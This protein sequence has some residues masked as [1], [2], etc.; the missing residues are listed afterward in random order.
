MA[1]IPYMKFYIGD[2]EQ[3]LNACSLQ[4]EAAWLKVVV[5]MFKDQESG[6]YKTTTK[7]LQRIWKCSTNDVQEII[8]ELKDEMV[9]GIEI[10]GDDVVFKNRRMLKAKGISKIRSDAVQNRYKTS[11]KGITKEVQNP[12]YEYEHDNEYENNNVGVPNLKEQ[13]N[14]CEFIFEKFLKKKYDP[15]N[16]TPREYPFYQD[17]DTEINSLAKEGADFKHLLQRIKSY[18]EYTQNTGQRAAVKFDS[19]IRKA[20]EANWNELLKNESANKSKHE[21]DTVYRTKEK[22]Y[23][24]QEIK[25]LKAIQEWYER[26]KKEKRPTRGQKLRKAVRGDDS[27]GETLKVKIEEIKPKK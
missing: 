12:E 14:L 23:T 9:C 20:F 16:V 1:S 6:I 10:N 21:T 13:I 5:K 17:V 19:V 7:R 26:M 4:T 11:T 24:P 3:D 25:E 27:K 8:E 18:Y 15:G 22:E 2:W